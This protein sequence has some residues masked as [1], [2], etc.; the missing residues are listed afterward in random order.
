MREP[1]ARGQQRSGGQ[2]REQEQGTSYTAGHM[3]IEKNG[4]QY[5]MYY[6]IVK[7]WQLHI[8]YVASSE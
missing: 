4:T 8:Y 7:G 1:A 3:L 5:T 2:R 6:V